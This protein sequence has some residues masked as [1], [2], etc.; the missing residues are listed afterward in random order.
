MGDS[1]EY[2]YAPAIG[3]MVERTYSVTPVRSSVSIRDDVG[4]LPLSF[5]GVSH[6]GL[7]FFRR[8]HPC[9]LDTFL[10]ILLS[11]LYLSQNVKSAKIKSDLSFESIL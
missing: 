9:P 3:R 2:F 4:N 6:L 10:V 11:A 8:G 5:S 1:L 7:S